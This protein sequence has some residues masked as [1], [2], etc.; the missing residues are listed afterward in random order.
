V[1][2][3]DFKNEILTLLLADEL[4]A[5]LNG[6]EITTFRASQRKDVRDI[7]I[8]NDVNEDIAYEDLPLKYLFYPDIPNYEQQ[9]LLQYL[10]KEVM[11]DS[12]IVSRLIKTYQNYENL[13]GKYQISD[14]NFIDIT[15]NAIIQCIQLLEKAIIQKD[16]KLVDKYSLW[17]R[18]AIVKALIIKNN[19]VEKILSKYPFFEKEIDNYIDAMKKYN[20]DTQ[21][22]NV[23]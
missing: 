2:E 6:K 17:L 15:N 12:S 23:Q 5:Q 3:I 11:E 9:H 21:I 7:W 4:E 1:K 19:M 20:T 22:K 10:S 18:F 8:I 13:L 14:I 16:Q